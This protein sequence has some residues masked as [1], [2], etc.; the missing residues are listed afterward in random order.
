MQRRWR[1]TK[2][3]FEALALAMQQAKH[4]ISKH[5]EFSNIKQLNQDIMDIC[6]QI[7]PNFD[8]EKFL[9]V[10]NKSKDEV[11]EDIIKEHK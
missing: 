11:L 1:M 5:A 4:R 8:R 2:K 7:N 10:V 3:H 9:E 6:E